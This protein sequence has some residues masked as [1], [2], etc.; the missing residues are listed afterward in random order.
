M[1]SR[2]CSDY[3]ICTHMCLN[4]SIHSGWRNISGLVSWGHLKWINLKVST[5][6]PFLLSKWRWKY[7]SW[8]SYKDML[9]PVTALLVQYI[10]ADLS[11]YPQQTNSI[12][13]QSSLICLTLDSKIWQKISYLKVL[14]WM[15]DG[16]STRCPIRDLEN[17]GRAIKTAAVSARKTDCTHG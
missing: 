13:C 9:K 5:E 10:V 11:T 8:I 3:I 15:M 16:A 17:I 2:D 14:W 1:N 4:C 7:P 6:K 12:C